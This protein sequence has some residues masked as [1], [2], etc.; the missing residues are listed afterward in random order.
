M[1]IYEN[2]TKEKH[3]QTIPNKSESLPMNET[4]PD[5]ISLMLILKVIFN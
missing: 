3:V 1:W 5:E 4:S 2:G